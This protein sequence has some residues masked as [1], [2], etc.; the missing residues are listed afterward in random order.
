MRRILEDTFGKAQIE[1]FAEHLFGEESIDAFLEH[2]KGSFVDIGKAAIAAALLPFERGL[3]LDFRFIERRLESFF[4]REGE[5][6]RT[7]N[8]WY[9][10]LWGELNASFDEFDKN[11]LRIITFNYDR[12]LEHYLFTRLKRRFPDKTNKECAAKICPIVHIHGSLGSLPYEKLTGKSQSECVP[13]D[14]MDRAWS[15]PHEMKKWFDI[16]RKNIRVIHEDVEETP[17]LRQAWEWLGNCTR[18]HFL[19]FGYH[20]TNIKRLK[21]DSLTPRKHVMGTVLGLSYGRERDV[22]ALLRDVSITHGM[23]GIF[24]TDVY[25]CLHDCVSLTMG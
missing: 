16:A 1:D 14:A 6:E 22:K 3:D 13:Y 18:I 2:Q 21:M 9:Q 5:K 10:L 15:K 7:A 17:E 20:P 4:D 8:N 12:S 11:K 24:D 23:D 25:T 19:G